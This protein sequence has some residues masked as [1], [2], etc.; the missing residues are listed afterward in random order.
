M[1]DRISRSFQ[2]ARASW[3]VL[4]SDKKLV[5]FPILSGL[6]VLLVMAS[7]IGPL[8]GL[9]MAGKI[10]L[11]PEANNGQ[12]PWW[13]YLVL[14]GFYFANYF[15]II[16]CNAA[17]VSC[18]ILRFNG[19]E[20]TLGDGIGAAAARLPQILAWTLVSATVGLILKAI[21]N[22]NEK[23]GQFI[24]A[25]LGT[26]W[27]VVT[28]FVIPVLVVEKLGPFAAISRSVALLKKAWGEALAGNF[29]LGLFKFLLVLPG[30]LLLFAAGAAA[31]ASLPTALI[32]ALAI[33]GV[34]WLLGASAI[35][36]A[37]DTIFLSALYQYAAFD[38]VPNGFD[39]Q[40]IE[41]AFVQ[42]KK[43]A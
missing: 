14:F 43:A 17:L 7:F 13:I 2:L 31:G 34:I 40:S 9:Q 21:E 36:A 1:F 39:R 3:N 26:A 11:D 35:G 8:V 30:I 19:E 42:K 5:I 4:Y 22:A 27:T 20:P 33:L 23:V 16:F 15:V 18:A 6:G 29:G 41:E 10:N 25:I 38:K 24:S 37:L 28:F 12:L 32:I